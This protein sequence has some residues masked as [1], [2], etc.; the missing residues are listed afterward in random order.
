M[1]LCQ[2]YGVLDE[3]C[4]LL[5]CGWSYD[6]AQIR[7]DFLS[8]G[9]NSSVVLQVV[10]LLQLSAYTAAFQQRFSR[11]GMGQL[12]TVSKPAVSDKL[13]ENSLWS[14]VQLCR[15][16]QGVDLVGHQKNRCIMH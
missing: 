9:R 7:K 14:D 10:L 15:N 3:V 4:K 1:R 8:P 16:D 13:A 12:Q 11:I 2:R 5:R 6:D